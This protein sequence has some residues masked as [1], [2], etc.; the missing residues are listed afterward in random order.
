ME[1]AASKLQSETRAQVQ[2]II[3]QLEALN[4]PEIADTIAQL[5]KDP[6]LGLARKQK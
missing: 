4:V 5:K 1:A 3:K 2:K 6:T